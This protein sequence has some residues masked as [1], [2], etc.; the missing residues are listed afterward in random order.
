MKIRVLKQIGNEVRIEIQGGGHGVCNLLQKK[1]LENPQV[2][3]AGYDVPHPLAP[4]QVIYVRMKGD[5]S[6]KEALLQ[7]AKEAQDSNIE[8]GKALDLALKA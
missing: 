7:A 4:I 1:L 8:F 3:Q 6:P 2:D 5:I